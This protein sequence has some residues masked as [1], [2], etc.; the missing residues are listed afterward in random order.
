MDGFARLLEIL[1]RPGSFSDLW[2]LCAAALARIAAAQSVEFV[3]EASDGDLPLRVGNATYGALRLHDPGELAPDV[4][5][6]LDACALLLATRLERDAAEAERARLAELAFSDGLTGISNRRAFDETLAREWANAER[7]G[8][9]L[10]LLLLDVDFF[11]LFNDAYGHQ[12]GDEC[13]QAVAQAL[14]RAVSRTGDLVA[15][16]GGEEFVALLPNTP[17]GGAAEL[18]ERVRA[19]IAALRLDHAGSSLR[20]VSASIGIASMRPERGSD[21]ESLVAVADHELYR[22]KLNGRNRACGEHYESQ[23]ERALPVRKGTRNHLPLPLAPLVGRGREIDELL[24]IAARER[25]LTLVGVGG[26]GK[27]R[28]ATEAAEHLAERF[29]DGAHFVDLAAL[30]ERE[31]ILSSIAT[32]VGASVPSGDDAVRALA[33][34]L[35]E[36]SLLLVLDNCEHV[37]EALAP[38][39][40]TLLR[41]G[42]GLRVL[43]TSREP[44]GIPGEVL[45][46]L[47]LLG[48]PPSDALALAEIANYDAVRL[49]VDRARAVRGAFALDEQNAPH[50]ASICRTLD[51]LPLAIELAAARVAVTTPQEIAEHVRR[52]LLPLGDGYRSEP[53]QRT[54]EATIAWSFALLT[55][56]EQVLL[57]R[58]AIF[59]GGFTSEAAAS[60]CSDATHVPDEVYDVLVRLARKSMVATTNDGRYHLLEPIRQF[61]RAKLDAASEVAPLAA[62]HAAYFAQLALRARRSERE[63][64]RTAWMFRVGTD[65]DNYRAALAWALVEGNEPALGAAIAADIASVWESF[66][67]RE[68]MRYVELAIARVPEHPYLWIARSW[69]L[70]Y[71]GERPREQLDAAQRA[72]ELAEDS[73]ERTSRF[74]ALLRRAQAFANLREHDAAL[75]DFER[76]DAIAAEIGDER[77]DAHVSRARARAALMREDWDEAQRRYTDLVLRYRAEGSDHQAAVLLRSLAEIEFA[78]GNVDAAIAATYEPECLALDVSQRMVMDTNLTCYLVA[79]GRYAQAREVA[80]VVIAQT[81]ER[82]LR[83]GRVLAIQH[84]ALAAALSGER[85]RAARLYGFVARAVRELGFE[86][87]YTERYTWE[88]L[89]TSLEE[90]LEPATLA[91]LI[92]A[93]AALADE[94]AVGLALRTAGVA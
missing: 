14:R 48:V 80:R 34:E 90:S 6:M 67:V 52:S 74:D 83:V 43:A 82:E 17:A 27:T 5:S 45:Y 71:F 32:L 84:M 38:I 42:R 37:L 47:P 94:E 86:R 75:R 33:D 60:V 73:G 53:R 20:R 81:W 3:A 72:L 49:F 57:R 12:R 50:V 63:S 18:A 51:G 35:A 69:M 44:L 36:R 54:M 61:A 21:P 62:R 19:E 28:L 92:A 15:R 31:T 22:A 91:R 93:G 26:S 13:L 11:K 64:A 10:S 56:A 30:H 70:D 39:V 23:A 1:G 78:R 85:E 8:T 16:Y 9:Q 58:L 79:A 66:G 24:D 2:P 76:A 55:G 41:A 4:R 87:E 59:A 46:E 65:I 88:R 7:A 77:Y 25:L 29:A 68:G 89:S 40:T